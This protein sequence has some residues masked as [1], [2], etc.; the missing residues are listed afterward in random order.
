MDTE[1][2]AKRKNKW[3]SKLAGHFLGKT[4]KKWAEKLKKLGREA[5][6]QAIRSKQ[7]PTVPPPKN[8]K[9]RTEHRGNRLKTSLKT[10]KKKIGKNKTTKAKPEPKPIENAEIAE[11][12]KDHELLNKEVRVFSEEAS[13]QYL[14]RVGTVYKTLLI[15]PQG[16]AEYVRLLVAEN[17]GSGE[18][19]VGGLF[20]IKAEFCQDRKSEPHGFKIKPMA[21][22][23]RSLKGF[24]KTQIQDE[25][26]AVSHPE[27]LEL[28]EKDKLIELMT[29]KAA[30]R[31]KSLRLLGED[32]S[33]V[34][35]QSMSRTPHSATSS[36]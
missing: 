15:K 3:A 2:K 30:L 17:T 12:L 14:G 13:P 29:I 6:I 9:K 34:S 5:G 24:R 36:I 25:L 21:F 4:G 31:E 27:N 32:N 7:K 28:I 26:E 35:K 23:F 1:R 10:V 19:K 33:E 20:A 8:A 16:E 11:E 18:L 22:D